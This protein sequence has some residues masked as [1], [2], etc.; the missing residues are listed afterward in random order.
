[1][2]SRIVKTFASLP[3]TGKYKPLNTFLYL[4]LLLILCT[5]IS[6]MKS[7][8]SVEAW[9]GTDTQLNL[10]NSNASREHTAFW[11]SESLYFCNV[12]V[13]KACMCSTKILLG[14]FLRCRWVF[15]HKTCTFQVVLST[16][17]CSKSC[18]GGSRNLAC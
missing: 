9:C 16:H 5:A 15:W 10:Q 18:R 7:G 12:V 17:S 13:D 6:T 14:F 8:S 2:C 11:I 3:F 4:A 1:M